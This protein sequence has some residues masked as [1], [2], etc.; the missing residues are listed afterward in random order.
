MSSWQ[1]PLCQ[2]IFC[3]VHGNAHPDMM[4]SVYQLTPEARQLAQTEQTLS[5][6]T[7]PC[8]H[9]GCRIQKSHGCDHVICGHCHEDMCFKCGTH[10]YLSGT[11]IRRCE[12]CRRDYRD[13]R[14]DHIY[15]IRLVLFLPL[16]LPMIVLYVALAAVAAVVT[17]CFGGCF[18]CGRCFDSKTSTT[19]SNSSSNN[20]N[21]ES[22]TTASTSNN[23]EIKE[24]RGTARHGVCASAI[25][26]FLPFIVLLEDFGIHLQILDELF[27]EPDN[28]M[29]VMPVMAVAGTMTQQQAMEETA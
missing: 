11:M 12:R 4:C 27:P 14:Y 2:H 22:T 24:K 25:V 8:S 17:G 19:T 3:L 10:A 15:R 7:K 18:R 16:L 28:E 13:H 26:I 1:C 29:P 5:K 21:G 6:Y 23:D 20:N 9:C